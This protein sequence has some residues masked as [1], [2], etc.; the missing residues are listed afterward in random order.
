MQYT[1][2]KFVTGETFWFDQKEYTTRWI[3]VGE[4][5]YLEV[6]RNNSIAME[7]RADNILYIRHDIYKS[8]KKE[9]EE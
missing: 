7:C 1:I 3:F 9:A 2:I 8:T 5:R 6:L 4:E